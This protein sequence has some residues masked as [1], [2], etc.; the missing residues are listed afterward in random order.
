MCA[1]SKAERKERGGRKCNRTSS[2]GAGCEMRIV[3]IHLTTKVVRTER[4]RKA[5]NRHS[6][7]NNSAASAFSAAVGSSTSALKGTSAKDCLGVTR[8]PA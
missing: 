5:R 1:T 6:S 3:S 7:G 4:T 2:G 8:K